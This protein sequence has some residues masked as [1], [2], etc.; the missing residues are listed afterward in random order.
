M[1]LSSEKE[2][3][4]SPLQS[5]TRFNGER[6]ETGLLWRYDDIRLPDNREMALRRHQS[7]QNRMAKDEQI[8]QALQQKIQDYVM[9]GWF[10]PVFPV[11]NSLGR[12]HQGLWQVI[13]FSSTGRTGFTFISTRDSTSI[14]LASYCSYGRHSRDVLSGAHSRRRSALSVLL[15]DECRW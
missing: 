6:Y 4:Q 11:T 14:P 10:L 7:L 12:C 13:E 2:R 1:L 3:S 9:K 8:A 15:L 5:R